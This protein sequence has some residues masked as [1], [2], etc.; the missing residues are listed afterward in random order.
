MSNKILGATPAEDAPS[1][2]ITAAYLAREQ[3][4]SANP[5]PAGT[6]NHTLF[7]LCRWGKISDRPKRPQRSQTAR[8]AA[9]RFEEK[10]NARFKRP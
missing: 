5:Y 3:Q 9:L 8:L 6:A 4:D 7:A 1:T 2:V 10:Q